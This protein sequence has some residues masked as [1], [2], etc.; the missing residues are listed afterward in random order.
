MPPS[1]IVSAH[2][3][4][5]FSE[6]MLQDPFKSTGTVVFTPTALHMMFLFT[7]MQNIRRY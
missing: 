6:R 3:I 5:V 4:L 7:R 2:P 1:I